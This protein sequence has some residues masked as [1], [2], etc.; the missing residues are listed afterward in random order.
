V[1]GRGRRNGV[2][3]N[4]GEP[5]VSL[6]GRAPWGTASAEKKF[7]GFNIPL[8]AMSGAM[9]FRRVTPEQQS[10]V[11][12]SHDWISITIPMLGRYSEAYGDREVW[13]GGPAATLHPHGEWH[14][15]RVASLGAE[16]VAIR[17]DP[18]RLKLA[19]YDLR[20]DR[21]SC[22]NGGRVGAA[23]RR[24]ATSW[25]DE[26]ASEEELLQKTGRFLVDAL[27]CEENASAPPWLGYILEKLD[28]PAPFSTTEAARDLGLHPAWVARAYRRIMGEGILES[29]SRRRVD[30]AFALLRSTDLPLAEIAAEV[31]FCD[32]SHMNRTFKALA[33]RTPLQVRQEAR[34]SPV[35]SLS[36]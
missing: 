1:Q 3:P 10:I 19:G 5:Q 32:Q 13:L 12:H 16:A 33:G 20:I 25:S 8:R 9:A 2:P 30:R 11:G 4:E 24:L 18:V 21:T 15:N 34:S 36:E 22:W 31:G 35:T 29:I 27:A 26:S 23:A 6:T 17:L 14:G 7:I 28:D